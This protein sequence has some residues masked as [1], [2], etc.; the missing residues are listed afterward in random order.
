MICPVYIQL[1]TL[2]ELGKIVADDILNFFFFFQE[3]KTSRKR[4]G[5]LCKLSVELVLLLKLIIL[6]SNFQIVLQRRLLYDII[7]VR[8]ELT[9]DSGLVMDCTSFVTKPEQTLHD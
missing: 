7:M 2:K 6:L 4:L 8:Q 9:A 1:L 5:I 3:K